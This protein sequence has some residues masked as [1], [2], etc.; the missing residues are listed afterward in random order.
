MSDG[1]KQDRAYCPRCGTM[2]IRTKLDEMTATYHPV[3][4]TAQPSFAAQ[5]VQGAA[6]EFRDSL[7]S[8]ADQMAA[9]GPFPLAA[10]WHGWALYDAFVAGAKY[11]TPPSP[12]VT[13]VLATQ[14][15][16]TPTGK[17]IARL[18]ALQ[19]WLETYHPDLIAKFEGSPFVKNKA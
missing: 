18:E 5:D 9:C 3:E 17:H 13:Q 6:V 14:D 7:V 10:Y 19:D 16:L 4:A 8:R 2:C 15:G 11:A 1:D 12:R